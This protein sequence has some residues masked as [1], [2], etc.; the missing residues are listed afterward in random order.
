[1]SAMPVL[2]RSSPWLPH[3][4]H[5]L[6]ILLALLAIGPGL[7]IARA[8]IALGPFSDNM[9]LQRQVVVP[10]F[11]KADAGEQVTVEFRGQSRTATA[12][13]DGAW[14]VSLAAME[15]G[16]PFEMILKGKNTVTL[17]NVMVGEVWL[18]SGQSNMEWFMGW[19]PNNVDS[20]KSANFPD[21]RYLSIPKG[22]G[23]WVVCT[24]Q[25]ALDFSAV[26][27]YFGREIHRD[28]KVPVGII[29]NAVGGTDIERW[30]E[31]EFIAKD[32]ELS[33]PDYR[34]QN[35]L[36]GDLYKHN[37]L[38][39]AP[40]ALRGFLWYQGEN[41]TYNPQHYRARFE[42]LVKGWRKVWNQGQGDLPFYSV[43]LA[44]FHALQNVPVQTSAWCDIRE[45]QRLSL[46]VAGTAMATAIDIGDAVDIHPAN[47]F[48]VGRR[49]SLPARALVYGRSGLV[50][51][52][53][54]YASMVVAGKNLRLRFT[55]VGGGLRSKDG[56]PLKGFAIAGSDGN[57]AYA[58]ARIEGGEVVVSSAQVAA[59]TQARYAWADNPVA[60]LVNQEGLPASSFKTDG[61]QLPVA[62]AAPSSGKGRWPGIGA[63]AGTDLLGRAGKRALRPRFPRYSAR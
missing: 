18:G 19:S 23:K 24:P 40:Y 57:W 50:Y 62:L 28:L 25:A 63:P 11:G 10:V 17:R 6:P 21:I 8:N 42:G 15:A 45:A 36:P 1:M 12:A 61:P 52:G 14:K 33:K 56:G 16:G 47:K 20:A 59:P 51:S 7:R 3:T 46:S 53:P 30:L 55:H 43:Q 32:P 9:V 34:T 39:M 48:E 4:L 31:P 38:P 26:G 60:N 54:L 37:I 27:Y 29:V 13:A 35:S 2:A 22:T 58:D 41:N 44:A 49:L 5:T